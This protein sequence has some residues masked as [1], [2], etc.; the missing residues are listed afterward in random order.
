[1]LYLDGSSASSTPS[2]ISVLDPRRSTPAAGRGRSAANVRGARPPASD[3]PAAVLAH[4][5]WPASPDLGRVPN[6]TSTRTCAGSS[7][8]P[9]RDGGALVEQMHAHPLVVTARWPARTWVVEGAS[10]P[11]QPP[12]HFLL[13]AYS[14]GVGVLDMLAAFY[15]DT[16]DEAGPRGLRPVGRRLCRPPGNASAFMQDLPSGSAESRRPFRAVRDQV[17]IE[18]SP[19]TATGASAT[20]DR[21]APPG[22]F[23]S[24]GCRAA[25]LFT[26]ANHSARRGSRGEQDWASPSTTSLACGRCRSS[27]SGALRLP[28]PT[29]WWPRCR[30]PCHPGGRARHPATTTSV[31][32][33]QLRADI[34]D[35]LERLRDPT[36]PPR[37]Q[38]ALRP[39]QGRRRRRGGQCCR[40]ASS[41]AWRCNPR[42]P[43][44]RFGTFRTCVSNVP[45]PREPRYLGRWRVD[46]WFSTG[47]I[48][49]R[50][51]RHDR[52][53]LLRPVQ[54][55]RNGRRS[56]GSNT[57][58]LLGGFR[59]SHEEAARGGRAQYTPKEMAASIRSICPSC[60]WAGQPA[61]TAWPLHGLRKAERTGNRH[62]GAPVRCLPAQPGLAKPSPG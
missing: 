52:L 16:P 38:T 57:W 47:Q 41:R 28:P 46:Q 42:A 54:P 20:F 17:R 7:V 1:M 27:L 49:W 56:P 29:R 18:R 8:P 35:P 37:P 31:D 60:C 25:G 15:N 21:S 51:A 9:G 33:V 55:V 26:P 53:E 6:S 11:R 39:D 23:P 19:K 4:T 13:H 59:A 45:G 2:K 12:V 24:A 58:E 43:K 44:G 14:D 62:S 61:L 32:C 50:H 34:A 22:P 36:S 30:S 5:R 3:L 40:N 10:G 48:S